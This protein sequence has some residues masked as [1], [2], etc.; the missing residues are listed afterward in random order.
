MKWETQWGTVTTNQAPNRWKPN[1]NWISRKWWIDLAIGESISNINVCSK[2][3]SGT[4]FNIDFKVKSTS[5]W[6]PSKQYSVK[7]LLCKFWWVQVKRL[8]VQTKVCL[9]VLVFCWCAHWQDHFLPKCEEHQMGYC[10]LMQILT[11]NQ[12]TLYPLL[13]VKESYICLKPHWTFD[14][15]FV[16]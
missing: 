13:F 16:T 7:V 12:Y 11:E 3:Y 1:K 14:L 15:I 4:F 5:Y 6:C 2:H 8:S 9:T 10:Q